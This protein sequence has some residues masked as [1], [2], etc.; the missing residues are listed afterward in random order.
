MNE[1][2]EIHPT[3][4][5]AEFRPWIFQAYVRCIQPRRGA[6]YQPRASAAASAAKR[7][8][9]V[10]FSRM[11]HNSVACPWNCH[12]NCR[13]LGGILQSPLDSDD[14]SEMSHEPT[15]DDPLRA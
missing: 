4:E 9:G 8:P 15:A 11:N 7:R 2:F 12:L 3:Q 5:C 1:V 14:A 10:V 6:T 13:I